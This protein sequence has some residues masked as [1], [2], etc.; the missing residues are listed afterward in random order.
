MR[1]GILSSTVFTL[2][3]TA[4]VAA[5][6]NGMMSKG[7]ADGKMDKM[8]ADKSYT[9]CVQKDAKTGAYSLSK[10]TTAD[11]MMKDGMAKDGMAKD[12]SM[13][14]GKGKDSM[15]GDM[16]LS[17]TSK[18][19]DLSKHVGHKVTVVG[20][21]AMPMAMGKD[22]GMMASDKSMAKD[23]SMDKGMEMSSFAIKT[24]TMVS[25]SCQ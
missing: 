12:N 7:M 22:M 23:K 5:Q 16:W 25:S 18:D 13:A 8:S 19:I 4:A 1:Y 3:V 6:S 17:V 21:G 24:L 2:V 20:S 10:V 14:M 9:G 11:A 15:A